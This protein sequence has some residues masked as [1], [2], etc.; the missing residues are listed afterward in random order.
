MSRTSRDVVKPSPLENLQCIRELL[1]EC[2]A[3]SRLTTEEVRLRRA[4]PAVITDLAINVEGPSGEALLNARAVEDLP[5]A[6]FDKRATKRV[7]TPDLPVGILDDFTS[8]KVAWHVVG[9]MASVP[10]T[11][12]MNTD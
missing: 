9:P 7:S 5:E 10:L 4:E 6:L 1:H 3:V 12:G 2:S 8:K 11:L